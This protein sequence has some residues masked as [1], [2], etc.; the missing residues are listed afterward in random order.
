MFDMTN[1]GKNYSGNYR[2][3]SMAMAIPGIMLAAPL[4]GFFLGKALDKW[5]NTKSIFSVIL[6]FLGFIAGFKETY[7][8]IKRISKDL[9]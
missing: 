1:S 4:I 8:I 3:I 5:L 7:N 9:R 6:L 2:T